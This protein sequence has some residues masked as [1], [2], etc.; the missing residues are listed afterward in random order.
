MKQQVK[1]KLPAMYNKLYPLLLIIATFMMGFAYATVNGT[2]LEIAA[3]I[4]ALKE[5]AVVIS[6]IEEVSSTNAK[7]TILST[8]G[9]LVNSHVLLSLDSANTEVTY[10][11]TIFNNTNQDYFFEGV[12]CDTTDPAFYSNENIIYEATAPTPGDIL[13]INRSATITLKFKYKDGVIPTEDIN[14][15]ESFINFKFSPVSELLANI[16]TSVN[17][18]TGTL[19][20]LTDTI[21]YQIT[22]KNN[23][24]VPI[25]YS[26]SGEQLPSLTINGNQ[27]NLYLAPGA[28]NTTNLTILPVANYFSKAEVVPIDTFV[29]LGKESSANIATHTINVTLPGSPMT[30]YLADYPLDQTTADFTQNIITA[31]ASGLFSIQDSSGTAKYFRGIV[32]NNYVTFANQTWRILRVNSDG[33]TRL[34]LDS[35]INGTIQF[36]GKGKVDYISSTLKQELDTWYTANLSSHTRYINNSAL[37]IHDN[38]KGNGKGNEFQP[39]TRLNNSTPNINT[40]SFNRMHLF[41]TSATTIGN[42]LL[43]NP[44]GTL[45]VDELMLAGTTVSATSGNSLFFIADNVQT[46]SSLWS[47]SPASNSEVIG[48]RANA[49]FQKMSPQTTNQ[50]KPVIEL[51]AKTLYK[52]TGTKTNPYIITN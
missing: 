39:Q 50:L 14:E 48:F 36:T 15:L 52:G 44:I 17:R 24:K 31:E 46:T 27:T 26:V 45:T 19:V 18:T 16:E 40:T 42:G 8:N 12:L 37:F 10:R 6:K 25:N 7:F 13:P 3:S 2:D 23:N 21:P 29:N 9:T 43:T 51:N 22:I 1:K 28:T 49:G 32:T 47:M 41:S 20:E 5:N 35:P 34:I 4:N 38:V 11:F 30:R 33:T